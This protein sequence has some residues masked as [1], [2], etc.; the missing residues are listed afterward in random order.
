M[1]RNETRKINRLN[2]LKLPLF[3]GNMIMYIEN[4]KEST[5]KLPI[6]E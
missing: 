4:A 1:I 5:T 2:E 3:A 6:V